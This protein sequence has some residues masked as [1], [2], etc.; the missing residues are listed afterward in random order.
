MDPPSVAAAADPVGT[1]PRPAPVPP[2]P[3][4]T[5]A[6]FTRRTVGVRVERAE[7][8]PPDPTFPLLR[9]RFFAFTVGGFLS[10]RRG[11]SWRHRGSRARPSPGCLP[12]DL[13]RGEHG[14][15]AAH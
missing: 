3:A 11:R 6:D 15:L 13:V 8:V 1:K 12:G 7:V 9:T 5:M 14:S 2:R 10:L 4:G